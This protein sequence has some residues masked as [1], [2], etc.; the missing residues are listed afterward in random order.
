M[1]PFV[2]PQG[3]L[4]RSRVVPDVRTV[5]VDAL[6]RALTGYAVVEPQETLLL[7]DDSKGVLTFEAGVPVLAYH[8]GTDAG[9]PKA[10]ADLATVGPCRLELY[11]LTARQLEAAHDTPELRVPPGMPA[12][13]LAGDP[14][15]ADQTRE[16]AP[17]DRRDEEPDLDA[18]EAFLEDVEQID[19]IREQA[20]AE[21][22][23]RAEEW[24]LDGQLV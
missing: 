11:A 7:G 8:T 1:T 16:R 15:L 13:R 17:T 18:V 20:R 9:G 5:L 4:I 22:K 23:R 24:G 21:A 10:L 6:D 2:V 3:K 14:A 19:A 12:E